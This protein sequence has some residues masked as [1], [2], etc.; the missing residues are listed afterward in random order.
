MSQSER[1]RAG[2]WT[3]AQDRIIRSTYELDAVE[4][5]GRVNA[6]GPPHSMNALYKRRFHLRIADNPH[7]LPVVPTRKLS[8]AGWPELEGTHEERDRL[9]VR[10][11][12]ACAVRCG[13]VKIPVAA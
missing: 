8:H 4:V 6:A 12:V 5:Q 13:L 7:R 10:L 3:A 1:I 2:G 11:V 9:F